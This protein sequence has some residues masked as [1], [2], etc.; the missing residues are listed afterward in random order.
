MSEHNPLSGFNP[1]KAARSAQEKAESGE[2]IFKMRAEKAE[3]KLSAWEQ[4]DFYHQIRELKTELATCVD[5]L[6]E[7]AGMYERKYTSLEAELADMT[8]L[9]EHQTEMR[10]KAEAELDML[11]RDWVPGWMHERVVNGNR[12]LREALEK[13]K[14]QCQSTHT[15]FAIGIHRIARDALA[16]AGSERESSC[17]GLRDALEGTVKILDGMIQGSAIEGAR[18]SGL[19]GCQPYPSAGDVEEAIQNA[20]NALAGGQ[21]DTE[22]HSTKVED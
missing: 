10:K 14:C 7:Q 13:I 3:A 1:L 4:T 6:K 18:P 12:V 2:N 5:R 22:S 16:G 20:R 11:Q 8:K 9:A 15:A 17:P 21:G 19:Y